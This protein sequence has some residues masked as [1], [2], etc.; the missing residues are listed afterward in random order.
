[1][2][3]DLSP[4]I[5]NIVKSQI[6]LGFYNNYEE[7]FSDA[8][9]ILEEVNLSK[10][11]KLDIIKNLVEEGYQSMLNEPLISSGEALNYFRNKAN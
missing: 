9:R 8:F 11:S 7:V 3:I 6:H 10:K 5:E 2:R 1:M 4:E